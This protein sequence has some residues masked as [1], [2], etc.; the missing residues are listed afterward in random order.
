MV[1]HDLARLPLTTRYTENGQA[2]KLNDGMWGPAVTL[3][4]KRWTVALAN[5]FS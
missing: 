1:A 4:A 2:L 5:L 3:G